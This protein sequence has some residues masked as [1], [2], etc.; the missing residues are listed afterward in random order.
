MR[1]SSRCRKHQFS[2]GRLEDA[3]GAVNGSCDLTFALYDAA[4]SGSPPSGGTLLGTVNRPG[5]TLVD[6]Y[7]AVLLDFGAAAF[8]GDRRWLQITLDCGDGAVTL[9]PRQ[10]LTAAPYALYAPPTHSHWGQEWSG[11]GIGLTL[12]GGYSGMEAIGD[13]RGVYGRSNTTTGVGVVG[14]AS[15]AS[16]TTTGVRGSSASTEGTG[17]YGIASATS[18]TTYGMYGQMESPGGMGAPGND[19]LT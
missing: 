6:G 4:G 1:A 13:A 12:T 17:V 9:A 8:A 7:F 3:S 14:Y 18:G 15:A 16:G 19:V 2:T 10:E 5:E 11:S